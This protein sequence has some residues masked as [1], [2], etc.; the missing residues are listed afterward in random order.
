[1]AERHEYRTSVRWEAERKGALSAPG[2]P[3][4][5]VA[6]PPEFPGGHPGIWSPEHLF[7]ASAEVCIMTTFL[8]IAANSK[9]EF[10]QYSSS[11]EGILE[12]TDSG[13]MF[14]EIT[15]KPRVVISD[16]AQRDRTLRILEKSEK[17]C[18]ISNSMKT[19]VHLQPEV[20]VG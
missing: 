17:A 4:L 12:K 7:V 10:K 8:A 2:L 15:V 18:L 19:A 13:Y 14:T 6:T 1:M 3:D 5:T 20:V 11:A 9:L 16:E